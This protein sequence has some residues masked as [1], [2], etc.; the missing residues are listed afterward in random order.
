[1][2]PSLL[3]VQTFFVLIGLSNTV[4]N[5]FTVALA[6]G[7]RE[8]YYQ[9]MKKNSDVEVEYQVSSCLFYNFRRWLIRVKWLI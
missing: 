3:V 9:V 5:D 8:C 4:D 7:K 2:G 1:M 6:A